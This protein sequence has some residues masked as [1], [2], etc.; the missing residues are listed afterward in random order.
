MRSDS[1]ACW[2]A[3]LARPLLYVICCARRNC[4]LVA[5]VPPPTVAASR[6][7]ASALN[8]SC[9]S[10]DQPGAKHIHL[11][12][13]ETPAALSAA[14]TVEPLRVVP[15]RLM[16]SRCRLLQ[17]TWHRPA[18]QSTLSWQRQLS[19]RGTC[20][21]A[22]AY[23][24]RAAGSHKRYWCQQGAGD[25]RARPPMYWGNGIGFLQG[26][27]PPPMDFLAPRGTF[28]ADSAGNPIGFPYVFV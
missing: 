8:G 11:S 15:V 26:G 20:I 5:A 27:V 17:Q 9:A 4:R 3:S 16:I 21:V 2:P 6:L 25:G 19:M 7:A 10:S 23:V 14:S 22:T 1:N 28:W 12:L 13:S 24:V 18:F